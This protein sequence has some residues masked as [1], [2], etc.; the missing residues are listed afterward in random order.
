MS[1]LQPGED[2]AKTDAEGSSIH[3]RSTTTYMDSSNRP[4]DTRCLENLSPDDLYKYE[5]LSSICDLLRQLLV[6]SEAQKEHRADE[7]KQSDDLLETRTRRRAWGNKALHVPSVR[8][9]DVF[10]ATP[11][12]NSPLRRVMWT[13]EEREYVP[14]SS[15]VEPEMSDEYEYDDDEDED[16]TTQ[17]FK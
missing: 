8:D 7:V 9:V 5:S 11:A 6:V 2:D 4:A 15:E 16:G 1:P 3:I 13:L 17:W 14:A 12:I 10:L